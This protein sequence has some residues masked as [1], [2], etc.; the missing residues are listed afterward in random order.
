MAYQLR[1]AALTNYVEV[2]RAVGLDPYQQLRAAR[3]SRS[4]LLD[5]DIRIP[6]Q[7][8][9]RLLESSANAAGIQDFGLRMAE[10]RQLSNLGPLAFAMR[11]E[12]TLR[13]ALESMA[14]YLRLQ[15]EAIAMRIEEAEGLVMLR[16]E[17]LTGVAGSLRQSTDLVVGVLYR[18]LAL[19]LGP[20]WRP[21]SICFSHAAPGSTAMYLRLF[22]MPVL[23]NQEFDGIICVA[24]DLEVPLPS[25]DPTM[26]RQVQQYLDTMLAQSDATISDK[27]RRLVLALL[28]SGA[29]TI[30]R[31][32][33][34]MG[35]DVRTVQRRL[36]NYDETF[37][38][39]VTATRVD[40][41]TRYLENR[42]RPLSEVATLLGFGSLS[43]FSRWFGGHFGCSVSK[44]RAKGF[45]KAVKKEGAGRSH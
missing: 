8:V 24:S 14:R 26:A 21:R 39:I 19:V 25:Y 10:T 37:S 28:P 23:F 34:H 18:V 20:K 22:G 11:Q 32:A 43:A 35:V 45:A 33:Q 3:I 1:S 5:P 6:A 38:A 40:L 16:Q 36:A 17:A 30:E 13:R 42:E 2:A 29:C 9:S 41:A 31:V 27:V 44:W 15:N 4:V 7:A 12:P